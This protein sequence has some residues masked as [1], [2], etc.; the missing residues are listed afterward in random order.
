MSHAKERK[1]KNCLNCNAMVAGRYCQVCGQENIETHE[2]F[3]HL[4]GHFISDIFHF[5]GM[6][7]ST[8][9]YLL[10]KPG[11]LTLEYARGRRASYLNPIKMYVFISAVFFLFF[12]TVYKP[13][14][15]VNETGRQPYTAAEVM[16]RLQKNKQSIV[17]SLRVKNLP[18][19]GKAQL[20]KRLAQVNK[21]I[22]VLQKDTSRKKELL[23]EIEGPT[24]MGY[25]RY[26]SFQEYDSIQKTLPSGKKDNWLQRKAAIRGISV[27]AKLKKNPD[28]MLNEVLDIFF[29]HFPQVLFISLPLFAF[30]LQLLYVRRKQWLYANH[31]IYT[32]HLY[33]AFFVFIFLML[34]INKAE[35]IAYL[36]WLSYVSV[37]IFL[38]VIYYSYKAMRVFYGQGRMKTIIKWI[39]LNAVAS[40]VMIALFLFL[41]LITFFT[42]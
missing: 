15:N 3:G 31:I 30:I 2:T 38:Y 12:L 37:A 11:Y 39:L 17:A 35:A 25:E 27:A 14:V 22:A 20:Q 28:E 42:V 32:V 23:D 4:A 19:F 13:D 36:N 5:D 7:F 29:H 16:Q 33:C 18:Q 26:H 10:F 21:N 9:K 1:D 41:F 34:L 8:A 40:V 6:F 24:V